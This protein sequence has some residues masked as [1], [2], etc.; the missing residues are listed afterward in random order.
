MYP[1]LLFLCKIFEDHCSLKRIKKRTKTKKITKNSFKCK[2]SDF[3]KL[4]HIYLVI[5]VYYLP[6]S[7][8]N[9]PTGTRQVPVTNCKSRARFSLSVL[10]TN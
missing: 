10:V 3:Y 5:D 2:S 8:A 4:F 7:S 9:P 1:F 6:I